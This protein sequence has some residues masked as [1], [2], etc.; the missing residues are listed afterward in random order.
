MLVPFHPSPTPTS[1]R[2]L[3]AG[4]VCFALSGCGAKETEENHAQVFTDPLIPPG[5]PPQHYPPPGF[6]WS[7]LRVGNLPLARYGVAAPPVNP[8]AHFLILADAAGPA[9]AGFDLARAVFATGRN[10]WMLEAPGQGGSGRYN[11][12]S[13]EVDTPDF[14]HYIRCARA[15]ISDIIQPSSGKPLSVLGHGSGALAALQ[16]GDMPLERVLVHGLPPETQPSLAPWSGDVVPQDDWGWI[17]WRWQKANPDLRFAGYS[18]RWL[19]EAAHA[20]KAALKARISVPLYGFEAPDKR[21]AAQNLCRCQV[22]DVA[23]REALRSRLL[24]ALAA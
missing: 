4:A 16:L 19:R 17:A 1:R 8:R 21:D 24:E 3:L 10:V 22:T 9:E 11:L 2:R 7:G 14:R 5:L 18:A 23:D 15:L 12:K 20:R 13:Q 6:V